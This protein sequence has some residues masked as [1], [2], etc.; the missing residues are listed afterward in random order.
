MIKMIY[1]IVVLTIVSAMALTVSAITGPATAARHRRD[2]RF[3]SDAEGYAMIT[4]GKPWSPRLR[5]PE[6]WDSAS[7]ERTAQAVLRRGRQYALS[8]RGPRRAVTKKGKLRPNAAAHRAN[9]QVKT[10]VKAEGTA[11]VERLGEKPG[12]FAAGW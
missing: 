1:A 11:G 10:G 9:R 3:A 8:L 4:G 5:G 7:V 6:N 2:S 12:D